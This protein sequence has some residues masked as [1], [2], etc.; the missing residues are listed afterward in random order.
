MHT[1]V[2]QV[3]PQRAIEMLGLRLHTL[4]AGQR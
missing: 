1:N 3:D 2:G 4:P